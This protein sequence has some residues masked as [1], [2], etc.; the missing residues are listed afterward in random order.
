MRL[1]A[2]RTDAL[3]VINAKRRTPI[4][5]S[6]MLTQ[7]QVDKLV[8]PGVCRPYLDRPESYVSI[9]V[10][11]FNRGSPDNN[12]G[13]TVSV[14]VTAICNTPVQELNEGLVR[15]QWL[16]VASELPH[17]SIPDVDFIQQVDATELSEFDLATY[18]RQSSLLFVVTTSRHPLDYTS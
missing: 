17:V 3:D 18:Y 8:L 12:R 7:D 5:F 15:A 16:T 9:D 2:P 4:E 11:S 10:A 6:G 13:W 14:F 1:Q